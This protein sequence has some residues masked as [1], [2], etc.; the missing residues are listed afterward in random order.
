MIPV[1]CLTVLA[2]AI[3][4]P[5]V[6]VPV[7][8]SHRCGL[9]GAAVALLVVWALWF[10]LKRQRELRGS[11]AGCRTTSHDAAPGAFR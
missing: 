9:A 1:I 10:R 4:L 7:D 11:F 8:L 2:L 3:M 6:G 5:S